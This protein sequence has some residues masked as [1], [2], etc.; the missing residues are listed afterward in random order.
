GRGNVML[1][2]E[3]KK[4]ERTAAKGRARD[5][6]GGVGRGVFE[7][8]SPHELSGGMRQRFSLC[9]ALIHDPNQ[10][11][12]DEPFGALDALTRDQLVLD[13]QQICNQ[14]RMTVLFVT[15]S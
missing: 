15:H 14:R 10:L 11:L 4:L 2:A 9:R 7:D 13:L 5:L 6:R 3:A 8:K 12:M 1:R